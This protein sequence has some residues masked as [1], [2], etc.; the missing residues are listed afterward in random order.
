[1]FGYKRIFNK[2]NPLLS[3]PSHTHTHTHTHTHRV[4]VKNN[5]WCYYQNQRF[6]YGIKFMLK[7]S[8]RRLLETVE[9]DFDL[10]I[11]NDFQLSTLIKEPT[12]IGT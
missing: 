9:K 11:I 1:M 3:L 2:L 6:M 7:S 12:K 5:V 8:N 10:M 4:L